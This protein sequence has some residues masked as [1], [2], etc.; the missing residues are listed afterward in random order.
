[1]H[2]SVTDP[3]GKTGDLRQ[4][5]DPV[6]DAGKWAGGFAD[7]AALKSTFVPAVQSLADK[8]AVALADVSVNLE[9]GRPVLRIA[10]G[11][12]DTLNMD[13]FSAFVGAVWDAVFRLNET[14]GRIAAGY[15]VVDDASGGV[16]VREVHDFMLGYRSVYAPT[17]VYKDN[18]YTAK[19]Q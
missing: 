2:V 19:E 14:M 18:W 8:Y 13:A 3:N 10:T 15:V 12:A 7:T 6:L 1:M 17:G 16:V 4:A 11:A 5:I 9:N